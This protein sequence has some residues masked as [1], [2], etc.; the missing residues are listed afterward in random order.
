MGYVIKDVSLSKNMVTTGEKVLLSVTILTWDF[1]N[2]NY[3]YET[4]NESGMTWGDMT[5][6]DE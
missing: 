5:R 1:L 6:S 4:L 2:K 3:T